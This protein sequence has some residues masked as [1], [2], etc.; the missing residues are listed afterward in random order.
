MTIASIKAS[1]VALF[2]MHMYWDKGFNVVAFLSSFLFVTL[3]IGLTLIDRDH[4]REDM[5]N[6]PVADRPAEP[7]TAKP[8]E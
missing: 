2:F 3:F 8:A 1:L 7:V 5:E 6:F 4:Y